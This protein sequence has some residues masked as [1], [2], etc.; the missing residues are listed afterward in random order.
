MEGA[1]ALI[2][3][4]DFSWEINRWGK[5]KRYL[6][7]DIELIMREVTY[8]K[9]TVGTQSCSVDESSPVYSRL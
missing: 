8:V 3:R 9:Q 2:K 5:M 7:P 6:H 4:K 1:S